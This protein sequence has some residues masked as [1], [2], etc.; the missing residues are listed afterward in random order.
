VRTSRERPMNRS[1]RR[2]LARPQERLACHGT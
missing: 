2:P 1:G